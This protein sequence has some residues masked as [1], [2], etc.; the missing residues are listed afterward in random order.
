MKAP[1][2]LVAAVIVASGCAQSPPAPETVAENVA[3]DPAPAAGETLASD[4]QVCKQVRRTGS[5][6]RVLICRSRA[7]IEQEAE[8]SKQTFDGLRN[9]QMNAGEY[10]KV[11]DGRQ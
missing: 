10:G 7:E 2:L 9:S 4:D 8:E 3:G 5:H 6:R 1:A 11:S